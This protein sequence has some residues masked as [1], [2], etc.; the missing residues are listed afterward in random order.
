MPSIEQKS[1]EKAKRLVYVD[2]F[3]GIA[4]FIMISIQIFDFLSRSSI[5][6]TPPYYVSEINSVTWV[7]PSLLFVYVSGMSLYLL[8]AISDHKNKFVNLFRQR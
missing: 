8:L 6:T 2:M 7:P 5:Y 1:K 4:I 3:R